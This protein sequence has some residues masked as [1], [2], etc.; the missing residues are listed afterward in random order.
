MYNGIGLATARGTGTN[1]YVQRNLSFVRK[2]KEK[3]EYKPDEE[4]KKLEEYANRRGNAE[5]L[6]HE[7]K[8]KIELKCAELEDELEEKGLSAEEIQKK[9]DA[10]RKKLQEKE[11]KK[12]NSTAEIELDEF[13]RPVANDT[14]KI[15]EA[16]ELKNRKLRKAFGLGEFDPAL[17]AE[18]H[19]KSKEDNKTKIINNEWLDPDD[20]D[21]DF[22]EE[23]DK[24]I[25][26][27]RLAS[28]VVLVTQ[29]E[30]ETEP[31]EQSEQKKKRKK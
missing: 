29:S 4:K 12:D 18:E 11:F 15:A 8:R 9:V 5:L 24:H 16:N 10:F 3:V 6:L 13:G 21:D 30:K 19:K 1:G 20:I 14:H 17:Q 31:I 25:Q 7:R 2:V 26:K 27:R 28:Q 22:D 23:Y